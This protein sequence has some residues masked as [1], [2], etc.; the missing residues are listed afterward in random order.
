ML[1]LPPDSSTGATINGTGNWEDVVDRMV[2]QCGFLLQDK[3][4]LVNGIAKLYEQ[5]GDR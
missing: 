1:E 4:V 2:L 3:Q 5:L